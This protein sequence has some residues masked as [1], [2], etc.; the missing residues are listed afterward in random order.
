MSSRRRGATGCAGAA[1]LRAALAAVV[2]A[3]SMAQAACGLPEKARDLFGSES[4]IPLSLPSTETRAEVVRVRKATAAGE[5]GERG[6]ELLVRLPDLGDPGIRAARVVVRSAVDDLGTDLVPREAPPGRPLAESVAP[7]GILLVPLRAAPRNA[8]RLREVFAEVQLDATGLDPA[9]LVTLP[10]FLEE[11]GAP[12]A[13]P[14]LEAAGVGL[15]VLTPEQVAAETA[16]AG[17]RKRAEGEAKGLGG[18]L[19]E[20]SVQLALRSSYAPAEGDVVLKVTDPQRR[21]REFGFLDTSGEAREARRE[22]KGG[23]TVLSCPDRSP[24]PDWSLQVHLR[25]PK[26]L[27]RYRFTLNDVSLR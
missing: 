18:G 7:G 27:R 2:A 8:R 17:E 10:R 3:G 5:G 15:A 6:I 25:T 23:F 16:A 1:G 14:A 12:L 22:E 4:A 13:S 11:T 20:A 24:G 26:A 21:V 19:L 9:S